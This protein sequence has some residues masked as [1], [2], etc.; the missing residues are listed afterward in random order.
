MSTASKHYLNGDR[1]TMRRKKVTLDVV[2]VLA[3]AAI[4]LGG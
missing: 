1:K 2:A 4:G 3:I